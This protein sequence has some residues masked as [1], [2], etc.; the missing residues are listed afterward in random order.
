L[1]ESQYNIKNL[2]RGPSRSIDH[3]TCLHLRLL[4][5][6]SLSLES[7]SRIL[8]NVKYSTWIEQCVGIDLPILYWDDDAINTLSRL[9]I[10]HPLSHD[11]SIGGPGHMSLYGIL[12]LFSCTLCMQLLRHRPISLPAANLAYNSLQREIELL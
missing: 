10:E 4:P 6:H 3:I 2:S 11:Q 5:A 7:I 1:L 8:E 9:Y 12:C